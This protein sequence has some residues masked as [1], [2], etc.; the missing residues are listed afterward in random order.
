MSALLPIVIAIPLL[1]ALALAPRTTRK[2]ALALA[3]WA[4]AP[5]LALALSGVDIAADLR[6]FVLGTRFVIDDVARVFLGFSAALWLAAGLYGAAYLAAD[7]RR[8]SYT[9][10][11]LVAMSGN[12]GL[13]VAHDL[14]SFYVLFALMSFAAYGLVVHARTDEARRAARVYLA[15]V[16]VG[17][18]LLFSGFVLL[19]AQSEVG[20]AALGPRKA[21]SE[22]WAF[23][24]LLIGFGI[25]AGALP[26]HVWLPLAHPVAPTPASAV[27]SGAMIKAGLV[28]WLRFLP[29]GEPGSGAWPAVFV[30]LG[31]AAAFYG[32][33]VGVAQRDAKTVLAYSSISQLG[34]ITVAFGAALVT[35]AAALPAVLAYAV[36][37]GLAKGALFLGVGI[38]AG[39]QGPHARFLAGLGLALA[40]ATLAGLPATSGAAAKTALKDALDVL[41]PSWGAAATALLPIAAVGTTLL[42]ARFL[43]LAW[44]RAT[45]EQAAQ[46]AVTPMWAAWLALLAAV[47]S[48]PFWLP[49][50]PHDF[51]ATVAAESV[52]S[53]LW[54]IAGGAAIAWA[55]AMPARRAATR[56]PRPPAGDVLIPLEAG[57]RSINEGVRRS[58]ERGRH[59]RTRL[60]AT[61]HAA[62]SVRSP[63]ITIWLARAERAFT[64]GPMVGALLLAVASAIAYVLIRT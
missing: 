55:A 32:A 60:A 44:P 20:L 14:A 25:K 49:G 24:L 35:P 1:L 43:V 30:A 62:A 61:L 41:P 50:T 45:A 23:P 2:A 9:A 54:P 17:E 29:L 34:L 31:L 22:D 4:A 26:L 5:A 37:H 42:M 3:P 27:L 19:A 10:F 6:W 21:P 40:A 12:L 8:T 11:F 51:A 33:A 28:G 59:A 16:I 53:S 7:P 39:A 15:L 57:A 58:I 63:S 56:L 64:V 36:H 18:L 52:L 47:A 48:S 13:T 38:A 46:V